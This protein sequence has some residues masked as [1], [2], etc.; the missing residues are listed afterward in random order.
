MKTIKNLFPFCF[1][2]FLVPIVNGQSSK[3]AF[4]YDLKFSPDSTDV[5]IIKNDM[6]VLWTN[7]DYSVF[8]SYYGYELDIFQ[9]EYTEN[10]EKT[11]SF[12]P[13]DFMNSR[14]S[15]KQPSA[16]YIIHKDFKNKK[17]TYYDQFFFDTF[18]FK[19]DMETFKW[20]LLDEK[21]EIFGK[22]CFKATV[23]Y[24][25]REFVAWYTE[26]IPINDGPYLFNGLPGLIL[27]LY[28]TKKHYHFSI[29]NMENKV[30]EMNSL[31]LNNAISISKSKLFETKRKY[32][33]DVRLGLGDRVNNLSPTEIAESQERYNKSNNPLILKMN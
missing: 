2:I 17:I 22:K 30:L 15:K 3:Y 13:Q 16:K 8:Q 32:F 6:L 9:K 18:L 31:I 1:L 21:K 26:E 4:F 10:A 28:D 27:E 25:G 11:G 23:L 29:I 7:G 12:D 19:D 20:K 5:S 14:K 24:G 33:Q